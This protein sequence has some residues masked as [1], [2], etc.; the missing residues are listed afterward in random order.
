[1]QFTLSTMTERPMN[2]RKHFDSLSTV[3]VIT[4]ILSFSDTS[5]LSSPIICCITVATFN[6][7]LLVKLGVCTDRPVFCNNVVEDAAVWGSACFSHLS[8]VPV[9]ACVECLDAVQLHR[10]ALVR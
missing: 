2:Y 1:M 8:A 4:I 5:L 10:T 6:V 9:V 3:F 7:S